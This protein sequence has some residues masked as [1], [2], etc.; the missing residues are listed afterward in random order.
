MKHTAWTI[1]AVCHAE[2][3]YIT[4]SLL[5]ALREVRC[6]EVSIVCASPTKLSVLAY[7]ARFSVVQSD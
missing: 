7:E 6:T 2:V 1:G 5:N 4:M 3:W